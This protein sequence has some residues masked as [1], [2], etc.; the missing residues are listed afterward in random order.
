MVRVG[1]LGAFDAG[2]ALTGSVVRAEL[3]RRMPDLELRVYTPTG[4]PPAT[5]VAEAVT[6][7]AQ[8]LGA[9]GVVRQEELAA[10]LDA[11]VISGDVLLDPGARDPERL[12]VEG[13]GA[14][15]PD[16]PVAWFAVTPH[17]EVSPIGADRAGDG[18]ARRV[19]I[20]VCGVGARERLD[21]VGSPAL[22]VVPHPALALPRLAAAADMPAVVER[23]R[24]AAA[25]PGGD[26][27]ALGN[28]A[29]EGMAN[30]A[31]LPAVGVAPRWSAVERAAAIAMADVY[32][33][34]SPTDCA[35]AAAYGRPAV[36]TGS[37]E[38][39]PTFAV[40]LGER[41]NVAAAVERARGR[42]PDATA[43]NAELAALDAAFDELAKLLREAPSAGGREERALRLRLREQEA[44]ADAREHELLEFIEQLNVEMVAKGPR[45]TALWRKI[46]EGDVHYHWYKQRAERADDE[47]ETLWRLHEGR[48]S[49]RIKRAVRSTKA[50]DAIAR[51]LWA[52]PVVPPPEP[53]TGPN[54]PDAPEA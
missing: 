42:R 18:L 14:F 16:V 4:D 19:A 30:G 20:W 22:R 39:V 40:A 13:L 27:V 49:V 38:D 5:G 33:G 52:G 15:E 10:T 54:D 50:G 3:A 17:G 2:D 1:L 32:V 7:S 47:I 53:R 11:A 44:S 43:I 35:V 31:R 25:L 9:F 37:A 21:A 6:W 51:A 8:P 46:H 45:F 29:L 48:R 34:A 12:L 26:Y 28:D 23:L 24:A 41:A 36:W